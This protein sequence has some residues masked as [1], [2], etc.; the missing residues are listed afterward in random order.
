MNLMAVLI[1]VVVQIIEETYRGLKKGKVKKAKVIDALLAMIASGAVKLPEGM[2][3]ET[4][5]P[6][7]GILID[8]AVSACNES[9]VFRK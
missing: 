8:M 2:T 3:A 5:K 1:P 9:G 7:L 6:I 4:V